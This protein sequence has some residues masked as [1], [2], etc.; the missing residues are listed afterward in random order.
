M[1]AGRE[2][3][4]FTLTLTRLSHTPFKLLTLSLG[5]SGAH[6]YAPAS[7]CQAQDLLADHTTNSNSPKLTP[8]HCQYIPLPQPLP[9]PQDYHHLPCRVYSAHTD[10]S[11]PSAMHATCMQ[12]AAAGGCALSTPDPGLMPRPR[13][14]HFSATGVA[15]RSRHP[16]T[17]RLGPRL[18][19]ARKIPPGVRQLPG[20]KYPPGYSY[21]PGTNTAQLYVRRATAPA[22]RHVPGGTSTFGHSVHASPTALTYAGWILHLN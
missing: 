7:T 14:I 19:L 8:P 20:C 3:G 13:L 10:L 9:P 6:S 1:A 15:G 17:P 16:E 4:R 5:H 21:G 18:A 22:M 12:Q 11:T 2:L